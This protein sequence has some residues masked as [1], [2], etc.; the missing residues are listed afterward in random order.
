METRA[1][2]LSVDSVFALWYNYRYKN[3]GERT[4]D[5]TKEIDLRRLG[6]ALLKRVWLIVL[7]AVVLAA[8]VFVYSK[9][10][11][12]PQYRTNISIYVNNNNKGQSVGISSSDLATSQRLV[13]TYIDVLKSDLVLDQVAQQLSLNIPASALRGMLQAESPEGTE[14]LTVYVSNTDKLL[15]AQI[16]NAIADV[17]PGAIAKIVEGSSAKIIDRAKVPNTPYSPNNTNNALLGGLIGAVIAVAGICLR[18]L[19]DVRIKDE[20]DLARICSAPVLGNIPD[21]NT[22]SKSGYTYVKTGND[23]ANKSLEV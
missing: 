21:F 10:F 4:M 17:A 8:A 19:L 12:A 2:G 16:A 11:I 15:A 5:S 1:K 23:A 13:A 3:E 7:C 9:N 14:V 20:E 18:V 22:Q 6:S